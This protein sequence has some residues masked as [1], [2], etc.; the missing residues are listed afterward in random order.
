MIVTIMLRSRRA[1]VA[2]F[3]VAVALA[4]GG[5]PPGTPARP[6]HAVAAH[7][8]EL[9]DSDFAGAVRD[10][11]LT[12][13]GS[14]DR[15]ARLRPVVTLLLGRAAAHFADDRAR[16]RAQAEVAGAMLLIRTGELPDDLGPNARTAFDGAARGRASVG[17]DGRAL[18]YYALLSRVGTPADRTSA[19]EHLGAV[20]AWS[21][22]VA[23]ERL[24][25]EGASRLQQQAMIRRLYEPTPGAL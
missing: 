10:L 1:L 9:S 16:V 11:L 12:A 19:A 15:P 22:P 13:P 23:A 14:S 21:S 20:A 18:A 5:P 6:S 4:C 17:D 2:F 24:T 3:P 25:V 8:S 7:G